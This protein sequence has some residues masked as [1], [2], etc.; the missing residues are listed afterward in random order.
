MKEY[1][2]PRL[3]MPVRSRQAIEHY[4]IS[5]CGALKTWAQELGLEESTE[6]LDTTLVEEKKTDEAL[7]ELAES[8][9]NQ[10]AEAA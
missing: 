10:H 8:K 2:E 1:R 7:T 5:R 4:E 6:L 9:V 3:W